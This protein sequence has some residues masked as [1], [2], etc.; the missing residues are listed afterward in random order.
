MHNTAQRA[1]QDTDSGSHD[2]ELPGSRVF[3]LCSYR[4]V[5][6]RL[7]HTQSTRLVPSLLQLSFSAVLAH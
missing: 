7:A 6:I 4:A 2:D 5:A 3:P 1:A